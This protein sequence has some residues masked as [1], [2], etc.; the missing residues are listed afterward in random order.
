M[1]RPILTEIEGYGSFGIACDDNVQ[2]C[3]K[4]FCENECYFVYRE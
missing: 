4:W 2:E 1:K 3:D